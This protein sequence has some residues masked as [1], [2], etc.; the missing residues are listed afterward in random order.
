VT[1]T[2]NYCAGTVVTFT[3]PEAGTFTLSPADGE[4]N[5]EVMIS[6]EYSSEIVTLPYVFT[7]DAGESM[8]FIIF[9]TEVMGLTE[10]TID[11]VISKK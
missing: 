1:V 5:A 3:A 2:N 7:L 11:L 10:D 6:E 4:L 8:E 9:T